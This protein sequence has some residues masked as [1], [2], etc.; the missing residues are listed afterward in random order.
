MRSYIKQYIYNQET[1]GMLKSICFCMTS[2]DEMRTKKPIILAF[3]NIKMQTCILWYLLACVIFSYW[4]QLKLTC[5]VDFF[6]PLKIF[7]ASPLPPLAMCRPTSNSLVTG[8]PITALVTSA[9]TFVTVLF[10]LLSMDSMAAILGIYSYLETR[11][12]EELRSFV[13]TSLST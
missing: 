5:F 7:Q 6:V 13:F 4:T 3:F 11:G 2:L 12:I 8:F 1:Q 10:N 9:V